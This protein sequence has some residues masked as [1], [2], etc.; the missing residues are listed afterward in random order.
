M[1]KQLL[2]L[3]IPLLFG[4]AQSQ[5]LLVTLENDSINCQINDVK[6]NNIHFTFVKDDIV[7]KTLIDRD[8]VKYYERDY[9]Y[10]SKVKQSS[11]N[12]EK[13]FP[14]I[15]FALDG[16]FSYQL[17]Q[18]PDDLSAEM[19]DYSRELKTGSV[20]GGELDYYF[21]EIIGIGVRV[22]NFHTS[23]RLEEYTFSS[24]GHTFT[25]TLSD[26]INISFFGAALKARSL[27]VHKNNHLVM[28]GALGYI[29][30]KNN[31]V[32][33]NSGQMTGNTVGTMVDVGYDLSLSDNVMMGIKLSMVTGNITEY[34]LSNG[35]TEETIELDE[36]EYIGVE[37]IE[38]SIGIRFME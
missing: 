4:T 15:R 27:R 13:D 5:D 9:F 17:S 11:N 14:K 21:S 24:Q 33:V 34:T 12:Q 1:K 20:F 35:T 31:F 10:H 32:L 8:K 16:G 22:Y 2:I 7:R 29:K 25:G 3:L 37:R 23:N 36:E 30:Y 19:E 28:G 26:D 6:E 18:L 38:L